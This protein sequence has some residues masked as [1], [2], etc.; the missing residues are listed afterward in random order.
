MK[1]IVLILSSTLSL[2]LF[3][4]CGSSTPEQYTN[5][6]NLGTNIRMQRGVPYE[7]KKGDEIEKLS[8]NPKLKID[9]N[10]SSGKTTVTLIDGEA[11]IIS[12]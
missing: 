10:L 12:K 1:K 8:S 9:T 11:A 2:F 6:E 4:A 5:Q 3:T 7:V